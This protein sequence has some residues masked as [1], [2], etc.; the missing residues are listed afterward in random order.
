MLTRDYHEGPAR[1]RRVDWA[2]EVIDHGGQ[3]T[4]PVKSEDAVAHSLRYAQDMFVLVPQHVRP[5]VSRR[6][7]DA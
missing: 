5:S 6:R 7:R 1:S 4:V 2:I 3:A